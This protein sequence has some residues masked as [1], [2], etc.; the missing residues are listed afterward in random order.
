MKAF[1]ITGFG[2]PEVFHATDVPK[3]AAGAGHVVVRVA[4]TSINPV[5]YKIRRGDYAQIAPDAPAILHGDIAGT[6]TEVGD[7]VAQFKVGDEVYGCAGGVKGYAGALAEYMRADAQLLAHKPRTLSMQQ[8][9]A[10]PLVAIT[11]WEALVERTK[12]QAGQSVLIHA[13]AGGVG[14]IAVQLAKARGA[15]VFATASTEDKQ[16]IVRDLGAEGVIDYRRESVA[17]Y[18]NEHTQGQGFDVVFDTVGGETFANSLV[19]ARLYG[20]VVSILPTATYD[21]SPL[22]QKSLTI[23][24]IFMLL[25]LLTG[26]G[27]AAH[28]KLLAEIAR[29][30][31]AGK[32]RP[33]IDTQTFRFADIARAHAYAESGKQI[34]K[35]VVAAA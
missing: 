19:A 26:H 17:D 9:A 7:D 14:H 24:G 23:H 16:K 20:Q 35:V 2:G 10:L 25:P 4:A 32:I 21:L 30:V 8:A 5:D 11:A 27:R 1:T 15:R 3:P 28:G 22:L 34:G 33:L 29:L 13:G 31:D 12:V 18:V 6:V